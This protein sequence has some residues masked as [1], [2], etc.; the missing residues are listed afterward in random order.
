MSKKESGKS[1]LDLERPRGETGID[2]IP[3]TVITM[4][5]VGAQYEAI[6]RKTGNLYK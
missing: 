3:V 4:I 6:H 2:S 1:V 5:L